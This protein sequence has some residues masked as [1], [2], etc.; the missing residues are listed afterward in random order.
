MGI[1]CLPFLLLPALSFLS[2][3]RAQVRQPDSLSAAHS[4]ARDTTT[5]HGTTSVSGLFQTGNENRFVVSLLSDLSIGNH[6]YQV[7]P[8]TSIAYSSKPGA[9]VE[10]EYLENV[11]IRLHQGH[12]FY[13]AAGLSFEKSFLRKIEYRYSAGLTAVCNI[14]NE[15]DQSVKL[16]VGLNYEFTQ[17]T[18]G[19][20]ADRSGL[21]DDYSRS[22]RQVYIRV[23]G[24]NQ[25][26]QKML[27][28][29][30][31]F[32]YQPNITDLGDYRWTLIGNIDL[33]INK[34]FSFR[35]SAVDSY[36]TFIADG[37]HRNNFRLTFGLNLTI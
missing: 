13:P 5:I 1:K 23:K 17:Y 22:V 29:S 20:F 32:F 14:V 27:L 3:A 36:E 18:H 33:P 6:S 30:Y 12:L 21:S 9:Q 19:S 7:L 8:L 10:G 37:V 34:I 24:K 31:D 15:N 4:P 11:I 35:T 26:F 2:S 28:L 16:G 25:L